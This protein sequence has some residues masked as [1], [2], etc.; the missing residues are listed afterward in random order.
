MIGVFDSG[1][2]GLG[3]LSTLR[4]LLPEADL[5]YFGDT[6]R[7]PYG[8]RSTERIC[9]YTE[10]ALQFLSSM[11]ANTVLAACGTVSS[12]ALPRLFCPEPVPSPCAAFDLPYRP[13]CLFGIVEPAIRAAVRYRRIAV[14]GTSA[15]VRSHA[16]RRALI[17]Q[18]ATAVFEHPCP[19]F[20]SL[21]ENGFTDGEDAAVLSL[22]SRILSPVRAF[23][24][25]AVILGCTHFPYLSD[26]IAKVLPQAFLIDAGREAAETLAASFR[27]SAEK[28]KDLC[29]DGA[30]KE[31]SLSGAARTLVYVSDN[32]EGFCQAAA[33]FLG[34]I[35]VE[36]A[37]APVFKG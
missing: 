3:A 15:T 2:G 10:E 14:L 20:V 26:A 11:G 22:V 37:E 33:R 29:P 8:T 32:A 28:K 36:I 34:D 23:S 1:I 4:R 12:V 30:G 16:F 31:R 6:A 9:R 25:D 17:K 35:Q 5:I 13:S 7:V 27:E 19:L 21:A 18:G 24:P